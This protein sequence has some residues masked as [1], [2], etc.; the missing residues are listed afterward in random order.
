MYI[1][2]RTYYTAIYITKYPLEIYYIPIYRGNTQS[3]LGENKKEKEVYSYIYRKNTKKSLQHKYCQYIQKKKDIYF[4]IY[5]KNTLLV[6]L[7]FLYIYRKNKK[8]SGAKRKRERD[9]YCYYIYR[10]TYKAISI[11]L[12]IREIQYTYI[13][14][15]NTIVLLVYIQLTPGGK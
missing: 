5:R 11:L 14:I 8:P 15:G 7:L 12:Y 1:Y 2:T 6:K 10:K 4:S 13:Y 3:P 9:I